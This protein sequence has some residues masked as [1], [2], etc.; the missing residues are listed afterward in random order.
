MP[1]EL[2]NCVKLFVPV[3][4]MK[5]SRFPSPFC[6]ARSR[7]DEKAMKRPSSEI[8]GWKSSMA[9]AFERSPS[10]ALVT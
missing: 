2:V 6:P 7:F 9:I 4:Q 5:I 1:E 3:S 10:E 8:Q